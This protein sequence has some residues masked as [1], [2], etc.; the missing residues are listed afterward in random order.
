SALRTGLLPGRGD[1][2]AWRGVDSSA[3]GALPGQQPYIDIPVVIGAGTDEARMGYE[4]RQ[5]QPAGNHPSREPA[6]ATYWQEVVSGFTEMPA[7]LHELDRVGAL[8]APLR[9]FADC[10]VRVVV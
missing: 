5:A 10:P 1:A 7:R 4:R 3:V 8:D 9:A 6:L 2:L